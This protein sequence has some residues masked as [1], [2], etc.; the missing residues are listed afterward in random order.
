MFAR[1]QSMASAAWQSP[2]MASSK[3]P[4]KTI[5]AA[6]AAGLRSSLVLFHGLDLL[7][8]A[9]VLPQAVGIRPQA[10]PDPRTARPPST[11][12]GPAPPCSYF[13]LTAIA[14][15]HRGHDCCPYAADIERS[16]VVAA[17]GR[18]STIGYWYHP[19]NSDSDSNSNNNNN[20]H[21]NNHPIDDPSALPEWTLQ[22]DFCGPRHWRR[23]RDVADVLR[24][25]LR[26][27][28]LLRWRQRWRQMEGK[29]QM[30]QQQQRQQRLF[31]LPALLADL[32]RAGA[33]FGCVSEC[34]VLRD[35]VAAAAAAGD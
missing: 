15:K 18:I 8:P 21:P 3:C 7:P 25:H 4:D 10:P 6:L 28:S 17:T 31:S 12:G 23:A 2:P 19:V 20:V 24:T 30:P 14:C 13:N 29:M 11:R 16:L 1:R 34:K 22:I 33:D 9:S 27:P 26:P 5:K 35:L 32:C